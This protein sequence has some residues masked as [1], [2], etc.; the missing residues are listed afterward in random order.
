[1]LRLHFFA[2]NR[3]I[4][5]HNFMSAHLE[6]NFQLPLSHQ[7]YNDLLQLSDMENDSSQD[8]HLGRLEVYFSEAKVFYQGRCFMEK[9][10]LGS[11]NIWK[12]MN[13]LIFDNKTPSFYSWKQLLN[14]DFLLLLFRLKER[15]QDVVKSWIMML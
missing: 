12:Q 4:F 14:G 1:M 13:G 7:A 11:W 8:F 6:D 2:A 9:F 15:D 5:V 3:N 10:L